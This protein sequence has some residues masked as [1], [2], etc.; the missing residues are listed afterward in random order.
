VQDIQAGF[1]YNAESNLD[2]QYAMSLV[3]FLDASQEVTLYQVGDI[4]QGTH[5]VFFGAMPLWSSS[6]AMFL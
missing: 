1:E 2:L 5:L 6:N 3:G 4:P